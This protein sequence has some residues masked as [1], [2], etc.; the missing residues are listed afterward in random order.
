[1]GVTCFVS[2]YQGVAPARRGVVSVDAEFT[3]D[4][5]LRALDIV[6]GRGALFQE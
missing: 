3:A 2:L 4:A 6:S 5:L 1:M